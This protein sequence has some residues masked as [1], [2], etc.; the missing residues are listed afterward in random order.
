MSFLSSACKVLSNRLVN[1]EG[2]KSVLLN[3]LRVIHGF[4]MEAAGNNIFV[5]HFKSSEE[6]HKI[7]VD[8][9]WSSDKCLIVFSIISE[10]QH[11]GDVLFDKVNFWV[12]IHNVSVAYISIDVAKKLGNE[13]GQ[14]VDIDGGTTGSSIGRY[15]RVCVIDMGNKEPKRVVVI[16]YECLLDICYA[17]DMLGHVYRECSLKNKIALDESSFGPWMKAVMGS[18]FIDSKKGMRQVNDGQL[19]AQFSPIANVNTQ[20]N[21]DNSEVSHQNCPNN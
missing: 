15:L 17:C 6:R 2:F 1:R 18:S 19:H 20:P 21:D 10:T 7:M 11:L 14:V 12:Q 5:L 3:M 9:L 8:G 16:T 13:I 4:E